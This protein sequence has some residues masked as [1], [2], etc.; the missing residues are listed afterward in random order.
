MAVELATR[1]RGEIINA[2]AM[3]MYHGLPIMTNKISVSEQRGIPHHLLG[4]VPQHEESWVVDDFKREAN[5]T[6]S[7]IRDRGN[8]PIV[9]GGTAYYVDALL[10]DGVTLGGK[11]PNNEAP[12][13]IL[14]GPT[15][16]MLAE[17]KRVD[18]D[19]ASRW[20]PNDRRKIRRTLEIYLRSGKRASELYAEQKERRGEE[21]LE[22]PWESLLF[23]VYSEREVLKPRLDARVDKMMQSGLLEELRELHS[24][25]RQREQ[26][27]HTVD[28]TRGIWQ[29]IGYKQFETYLEALESDDKDPSELD[30]I[31]TAC[32]EDMK[33]AT[34]R[35]A[36]YQNK[37]VRTKKLPRLVDESPA[38]VDSLYLLDST[39][40]SKY[41]DTVI[42]PAAKLT[43]QF[44]KGEARI[45][46]TE[47]STLARLVL[48]DAKRGRPEA[49]PCERK[50]EVCGITA[51]TEEMWAV[52][53]KGR[54]HR[55]RLRKKKRLALVP[56]ESPA[57]DGSRSD[58]ESEPD[59]AA[60][61]ST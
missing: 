37:W 46:P 40:V 23:W 12:I 19:S 58:S 36:Q 16:D 31:K 17:L 4:N 25:K 15:E 18:P 53:V 55:A 48:A 28:L 47:A 49:T 33:T 50:C 7:A 54:A 20:H 26:E 1:F 42:D 8:L 32:A 30:A 5:K 29:S 14:D 27:G 41:Q 9:V 34:R 59:I 10:H 13:P 51:V 24:F 2:D 35:Y 60:V 39:D 43:E 38:A 61:F 57:G 22:S 52:H 45:H 44:L 11:D 21:T 56:V 3:Q 6:I